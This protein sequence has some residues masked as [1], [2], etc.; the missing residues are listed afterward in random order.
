MIEAIVLAAGKGTRMRS[1]LPK[2]LHP[3]AGKPLVQHVLDTVKKLGVEKTHV[4]VGHGADVIKQ[5]LADY[6]TSF[7]LQTEQLGTAHAVAQALPEL[8]AD[9]TVLILYGDVPLISEET[10]KRLLAEVNDETLALLSVTLADPTGYGRILRDAN[11]AVEAIVEQKDASEEQLKI[12]EANTGIMALKSE[13]LHS[14]IP[15]INND[16]AQKEYYLTDIVALARQHGKVVRAVAST[17]PNEV[18]GV[19][20]R[21]QQ[22]ELE[23]HYQYRYA[24]RLM[25]AGVTIMD[26]RRF[27]CRGQLVAGEDCVIDVNCIFEGQVSLGNSVTI[28]PNCVIKTATILDGTVI[29]A[30][31]VIEEATIGQSCVVGPFARVRPGSVFAEG[32]KVGNFVETKKVKVGRGSKINHLSYVGDANLGDDVNVGAGTITCNYDGV[33]KH[34]TEIGDRVF[35]GSNTALVAPVKVAAGATVAAGSTITGD[36]E[37]EQLAVARSRQKNI[38]GWQRPKKKS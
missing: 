19:N 34:Q 13:C 2:V 31:T 6:N 36:V 33:N 26:P 27:D 12:N 14:L 20:N 1:A 16:N 37:A 15:L 8:S 7:V 10:L 18:L 24:C 28:G 25:S 21:I 3:L 32:A 35:I 17:D 22:A 5:Q 11:G 23:R 9:T 30:N 38:D 29:H 4:V